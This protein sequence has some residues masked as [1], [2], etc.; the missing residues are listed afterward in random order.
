MLAYLVS[1]P[2]NVSW[3]GTDGRPIISKHTSVTGRLDHPVHLYNARLFSCSAL[4]IGLHVPLET[5]K[6]IPANFISSAPPLSHQTP[7]HQTP[8]R[9]QAQSGGNQLHTRSRSDQHP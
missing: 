7:R 8:H 3:G 4:A 5:P 6:Q 2:Q 1:V 9:S